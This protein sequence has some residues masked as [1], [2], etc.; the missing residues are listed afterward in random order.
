[1]TGAVGAKTVVGVFEEAVYG[2]TPAS[3]SGQRLV[4][5]SFDAKKTQNQVKS[6]DIRSGRTRGKSM[7]GSVSV[8][9]SAKI[10]LSPEQIGIFF[11]HLMGSVT[12]T[13]T[14]PYQHVFTIADLPVGLLFDLDLGSVITG[15]G[16]YAR[17]SGMKISSAKINFPKEGPV[18]ISFDLVGRD[19]TTASV[20]LD[21]TLTDLGHDPFD[22]F[23]VSVK[24][25]GSAFG[26]FK[27]ADIDVSNAFDED[28]Y[29]LGSGG[30]R[31]C[32]P[33]EMVDI[34]GSVDTVFESADLMNKSLNNTT[35][36]LDFDLVRGDGLGTV[37]NESCKFQLQHLT[38]G[39][40]TP[41]VSGPGGISLSLPFETHEQGSDLG[42]KITL[43][44]MI[45]SY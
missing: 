22:V 9:I 32:L 33:E 36:S 35:S 25:G 3:P 5:E 6:N 1:M 21:A 34:T 14:G 42:L 13:G 23:D 20:P 8:T 41:G 12:T 45:A 44:N 29:V 19:M 26:F 11:K 38:Y 28:L 37:G 24:E 15:D 43:T 30:K 17:Y 31:V 4:F 2:E 27:T 10:N 39:V 16:R 18:N 7:L 40:S